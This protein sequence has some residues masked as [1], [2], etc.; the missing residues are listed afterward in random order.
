[1]E[2]E[3]PQPQVTPI[4]KQTRPWVCGKGIETCTRKE[5]CASCRGKR[6]RRMGRR[7]QNQGRKLL[8]VPD[9]KFAP[10]LAN[11]EN[12]QD[13]VAR[14]EVKSGAQVGPVATRFL[15]W[16][17]QSEAARAF[18]DP[19]PVMILMMPTGWGNEG[20]VV[21]RASDLAQV[22]AL[23]RGAESPEPSPPSDRGPSTPL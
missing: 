1:M 5:P 2:N 14:W 4:P 23:A 17:K 8:G 22:F 16:E 7:K 10:T 11:E 21:A 12:W 3:K 9:A 15:Q 13:P 6:S 18:G 20:L 19:R